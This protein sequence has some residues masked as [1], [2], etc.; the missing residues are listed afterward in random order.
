LVTP[1]GVYVGS[2]D[3]SGEP[4]RSEVPLN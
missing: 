3:F 2:S 1:P 4:P